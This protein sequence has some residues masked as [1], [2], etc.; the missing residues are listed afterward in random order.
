MSSIR[1]ATSDDLV[2]LPRRRINDDPATIDRGHLEA[3]QLAA[4]DLDGDLRVRDGDKLGGALPDT[5][6]DER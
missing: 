4:E 3:P 5:G 2:L 6:A 1:T